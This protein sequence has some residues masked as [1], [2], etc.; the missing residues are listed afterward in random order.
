[1][2]MGEALKKGKRKGGMNE[3]GGS[4]LKRQLTKAKMTLK[5]K[6]IA[7]YILLY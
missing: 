2:N 4:S 1:M 7:E 5:K 6:E 3:Q